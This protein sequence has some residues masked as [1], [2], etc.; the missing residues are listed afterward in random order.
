[1]YCAAASLMLFTDCGSGG[2]LFQGILYSTYALHT[3]TIFMHYQDESE[4]QIYS[5]SY[6]I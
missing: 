6:H 2:E 3:E 4:L 1:M 5:V